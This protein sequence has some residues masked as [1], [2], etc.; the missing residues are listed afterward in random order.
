M[1]QHVFA[2][3]RCIR[4]AAI[5]CKPPIKI[6]DLARVYIGDTG[7]DLVDDVIELA[8]L[9]GASEEGDRS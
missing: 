8:D 4:D 5:G 6:A 2:L 7:R 9:I 1:D 3:A